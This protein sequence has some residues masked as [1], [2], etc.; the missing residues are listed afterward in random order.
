MNIQNL[1][2]KRFKCVLF[3]LLALTLPLMHSN[4]QT[5]IN[6]VF[7]TERGI[8]AGVMLSDGKAYAE[9]E[10]EIIDFADDY[11]LDDANV[12][13][14][15]TETPGS[16][17]A[18]VATDDGDDKTFNLVNI[19]IKGN[20]SS[21]GFIFGFLY[22]HGDPELP[23]LDFAGTMNASGKTLNVENSVGSAIGIAFLS[24]EDLEESGETWGGLGDAAITFGNITVKGVGAEGFASAG[25]SS[26]TEITLGSVTVDGNASRAKG[27]LIAGDHAGE[28]TTGGITVTG[29]SAFGIQIGDADPAKNIPGNV[30]G[31]ITVNG[32]MNVRADGVAVGMMVN[33]NVDGEAG[34]SRRITLGAV[35]VMGRNGEEHAEQAV[36]FLAVG[37]TENA[38]GITIGDITAKGIKDAAGFGV[39]N[40][41]SDSPNNTATVSGGTITIGKMTIT[42]TEG[43]AFGWI[44]GQVEDDAIIT[45]GDIAVEG[46]GA[47]GVY[48][49]GDYDGRLRTGT[50]TADGG[51]AENSNATTS[52][53]A[54][55][56]NFTTGTGSA[57]RST[58]GNIVAEATTREHVY[59][60]VLA[61]ESG[62][63]NTGTLAGELT[64]GNITAT[65]NGTGDSFGWD[66]G[67][68]LQGAVL[69]VGTVTATADNFAAFGIRID[70]E[71][72]GNVTGGAIT[73]TSGDSEGA[74]ATGFF[75]SG[76][77]TGNITLGNITAGGHFTTA[78]AL[79]AAGNRAVG[80]HFTQ[81]VEG[82]LTTG[83]ITAMGKNETLGLHIGN[84][85][86]A[87]GPTTAANL[88][89]S[90]TLGKIAVTSTE[91]NAFGIRIAG[92]AEKLT[93]GGDIT[94]TG[95][96]TETSGIR[97]YGD[98]H[99]L[100][101]KDDIETGIRIAAAR[102]TSATGTY[103]GADI[104][105]AGALSVDLDGK[106]L[107]TTRVKV[108]GGSSGLAI[109]GAG[110]ADLGIVT[111][112]SGKFV[113]GGD[114]T[115]TRVTL[116]VDNL[117]NT[118]ASDL[119]DTGGNE[120]HAGSTLILEGRI[121]VGRQVR[122]GNFDVRA[123]DVTGGMF[124]VF[125]W[126]AGFIRARRTNANMSDGYLA[127]L[128]VHNRMAAWNVLQNHLISAN[129][130]G[131]N[132]YRGQN[133]PGFDRIRTIIPNNGHGI[134]SGLHAWAN[135]S[136]RSDAYQSA[137][138][139]RGQ[140][141]WR[142]STEGAQVGTDFIRSDQW[143]FGMLLGYD[144]GRM[145]QS[146]NNLEADDIYFGMYAAQ[147]LRNGADIRGVLAYGWQDYDM[148][149]FD[150]NDRWYF[151]SFKGNTIEAHLELGQRL[152]GGP[153]SLRPVIALDL[154]NNR[155][156]GGEEIEMESNATI[157]DSAPDE[158]VIYN[159]ASMTQAFLR[160]GTEL[161]FTRNFFTFNSGVFYSHDLNGTDLK[162]TV[163]SA[164]DNYYSADLLGTKLSRSRLSFHAAGTFQVTQFFSII[165]G[166]QGEY[167]FD[168]NNN[169]QNS[170]HIGGSWKW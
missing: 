109:T 96:G 113:V 157:P 13:I 130:F 104:W 162:A 47:S 32:T 68:I 156:K 69:T 87:S 126:D 111:V 57:N 84:A 19:D 167:A 146:W 105:T 127:A 28:L 153:W 147:I 2:A 38:A 159:K 101:N 91:A 80:V 134:S 75:A 122:L 34:T 39:G 8:H 14:A 160:T 98:T 166:Y 53:I 151:S 83:D 10:N 118:N 133:S 6:T 164:V 114:N 155:L 62:A 136:G 106:N 169:M 17:N 22:A 58:V 131:R 29:G 92:S 135:Y 63:G 149:R 94:A 36:G 12:V 74:R 76:K 37:G 86:N 61:G 20:T 56:G 152:S 7:D 59:G 138:N 41:Q 42:A 33:G 90:A 49:D 70:G 154:L 170:G 85:Y 163:I 79:T 115:D 3:A 89:G 55:L 119:R 137:F 143:Q 1:N 73:A 97:S 124:T 99:I 45:I 103:V 5:N 50:I 9:I 64:L 52:G 44:S 54:I 102:P 43:T 25:T 108:D 132:V 150:A 123:G 144:T 66:S 140:Q 24:I 88:L 31:L 120:L 81:D 35:N 67:T 26:D 165:G 27:V 168:R 21:A 77:N 121:P 48:V 125:D 23:Y 139:F 148:N 142:L 65:N 15:I 82:N 100:L 30:S 95:A 51:E 60:I 117:T 93:L 72:I 16:F 11:L 129:D 141:N 116:L 145:T 107:T 18:A 71:T 158:S 4:A 110:H 78:N 46:L 128:T 40:L 161:Q 112:E